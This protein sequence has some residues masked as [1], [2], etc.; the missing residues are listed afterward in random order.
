MNR[1][2]LQNTS[3]PNYITV[4]LGRSDD[5]DNSYPGDFT[6][7]EVLSDYKNILD[8]PKLDIVHAEFGDQHWSVLL[9]DGII[10]PDGK[11][12]QTETLV[13]ETGDKKR[14]TFIFDTGY[15][16]PQVPQ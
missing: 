5:P 3:T 16:F 7:G 1:I 15:T 14:L 13:S 4:L 2:F 11:A 12:L 6:I 8:E 9:E 10:G